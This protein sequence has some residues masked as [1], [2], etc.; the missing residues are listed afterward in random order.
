MKPDWLKANLPDAES[1]AKIKSLTQGCTHTICEE[2][3]CPNL[4][5]CWNNHTATFLI[6]GDT[7]TRNC[8]YCNVNHGTPGKVD[9]KEPEKV[10]NAVKQLNL[11]YVVITSP[12]RDDLQDGGAL[13]FIRTMKAI[14]DIS[15]NTKIELLTPDFRDQ[16]KKILHQ[17]PDVFGHNIETVERLFPS[18][19]PQGNYLKSMVFLKQIKEY[20]PNQIT[21]SGLMIGLGETKEEI[22]KTLRTLK[23]A[24]VDIVTIGQYLQPRPDLQKVDKY[25]TP[26]EFEELKKAAL[27]MGFK[28]VESAPLVRSSY[29]AEE[30]YKKSL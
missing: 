5:E 27:E 10:A 8:K 26:E 28:H 29:H 16:I 4:G 22:L 2:A 20:D 24:K 13:T 7:C 9:A 3:K 17:Q 6:L 30:A 18:I 14:K 19:R 11:S 12:T 25:Y 1:Y 23:L 15:P 21:K